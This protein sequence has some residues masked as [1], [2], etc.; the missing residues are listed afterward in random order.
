VPTPYPKIRIAIRS[1][2]WRSISAVARCRSGK[3]LEFSSKEF[4]LL[5]YF[6]CH[7][8]ETVS[9]DR[10]LEEVWGYVDS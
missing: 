8:G 4:E 9:R 7:P 5:K 3:E 6:L 2:T 1:G 10:L